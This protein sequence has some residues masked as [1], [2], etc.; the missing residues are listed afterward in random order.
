MSIL[1]LVLILIVIGIG[2]R[3]KIF[4]GYLLCLAGMVTPFLFGLG[5]PEMTESF[6]GTLKSSEMWR[7]F[8]AFVIVT[9]LGHLLKR[10]GSFERLTGAAQELAGGRKTAVAVLPAAV[11]LMPMPGGALLSAPLV[12]E[13]LKDEEHSPAFLAAANFWFRHVMEFFW[14]LYPGVMLTAGI[15]GI[16][17]QKFSS[18]GVIMTA[19]M[20]G[21]GY[22]VFL[23]QIKNHS[24]RSR[25]FS[26]LGRITYSLWP[27][28]LAVGLALGIGIDIVYALLAAILVTL[29]FNRGSLGFLWPV[30][31]ETVTLRLFFMV[32]GAMVFK[33]MLEASGA[34]QEIPAEV[35]NLG[36]PAA[37][38]ISLVTFLVGLMSGLTAAYVGLSFP[39]F[40]GFLYNPDINYGNIFLAYFSGY[41]GVL[42]SPTH[43]CL[44][45]STEHFKT[46]LGKVYK[47]MAPAVGLLALAGVVLYL[48]GYP[49][50]MGNW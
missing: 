3:R 22:L 33:D 28:L 25:T 19:A 11:G 15:V 14:P 1:K 24:R 50:G 45:L 42:L 4:V 29:I 43:F 8:A 26:A 9:V 40:A 21:A 47:A 36:I 5:I 23:R 34:V 17:V 41:L 49:W 48:L 46:D 12:A 20:I 37:I 16:S 7:L 30:I 39:I 44:L 18:I 27:L 13:V 10:I 38:I 6:W 31:R 35:A 2:I 32:F